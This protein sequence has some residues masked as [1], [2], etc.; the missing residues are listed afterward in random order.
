[1]FR[2]LEVFLSIQILITPLWSREDFSD[3]M[4]V[5]EAGLWT[6]RSSMGAP[7]YGPDALVLTNTS[8][9]KEIGH[10]EIDSPTNVECNTE[11]DGVMYVTTAN[12]VYKITLS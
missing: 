2:T 9:G 10:I 5:N 8:T 11:E 1:M 3:G 12:A 6:T 7:Q 4:C